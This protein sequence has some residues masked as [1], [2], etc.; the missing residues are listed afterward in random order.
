MHINSMK[1]GLAAVLTATALL[2]VGT[3]AFAAGEN[4]GKKF[5]K[6]YAQE[7]AAL[8]SD[9]MK[10]NSACL[11][12]DHGV[13]P[14][15]EHHFTWCM[16]NPKSTVKGAA[17]NIR[18]LVAKCTGAAPVTT[19]QPT[20]TKADAPGGEKFCQKYAETMAKLGSNAMKK[21]SACL[22]PDHGVHPDYNSHFTWCMKTPRSSVKGAAAHIRELVA[23]C[24]R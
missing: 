23:A 2:S 8:G 12:P 10:K 1:I 15:E 13:H 22:D 21:N 17:Q 4:G 11:D 20:N 7:M 5:C 9:A 19:T 3:Q 24:T 18:N 16:Q 14:S 6:Q